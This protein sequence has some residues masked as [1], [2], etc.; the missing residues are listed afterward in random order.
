[1]AS[2]SNLN[3]YNMTLCQMKY[4]VLLLAVLGCSQRT[5]NTV[6][7]AV[8][9]DYSRERAAIGRAVHFG[10][11]YAAKIALSP[12]IEIELIDD[13]SNEALAVQNALAIAADRN[14]VAVIG[15]A[16]S[17]VT[18]AAEEIYGRFGIPLIMPV[19]TKPGISDIATKNNWNNTLR[20]V[21][22]HDLQAIKIIEFGVQRLKTMRPLV[23]FDNTDAYGIDLGQSLYKQLSNRGLKPGWP[24]A[25]IG[26]SNNAIPDYNTILEKVSRFRIDLLIF[27]GFYSQAS[28]LVRQT[29]EAGIKVPII[30][31]DGCFQQELFDNIGT[32]ADSVFVAFVAPDWSQVPAAKSLI[33]DFQRKYPTSDVS[34]APFSAD[35]VQI[36]HKILSSTKDFSRNGVLE[37]LRTQ[38]SFQGIA[39]T[40]KFNSIGDWETGTNYIYQVR[41]S[42]KKFEQLN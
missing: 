6:R 11:E 25:E 9:V 4:F 41:L 5:P 26:S 21:P 42:A 16:S 19:A 32:N 27:A 33:D 1:M 13:Q 14:V 15:H 10:A 17:G 31:S 28:Y 3:L 39:G 29:R 35:A 34:Y 22:T 8:A 23:I 18:S 38:F 20:V 40:Y 12:K 36:V 30:L 24:P 37:Q 2:F 7:I